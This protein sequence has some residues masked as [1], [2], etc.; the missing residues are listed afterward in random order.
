M[1]LDN[2]IL[3]YS[4]KN[5]FLLKGVLF[6]FIVFFQLFIAIFCFTHYNRKKSLAKKFHL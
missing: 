4:K 5:V 3:I 6:V 1:A 2:L